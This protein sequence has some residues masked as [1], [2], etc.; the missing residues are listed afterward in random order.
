MIKSKAGE[1]K[2][3]SENLS[4]QIKSRDT[5]ITST[6]AKA[7]EL[8]AVSDKQSEQINVKDIEINMIKSKAAELKAV[9][10]NLSEQIK[11]K[12][13]EITSI[14]AEAAELKAVSDILSEQIII[15]ETEINS[16][17]TSKTAEL[18]V[19]SDKL[20]E[21]IN[22]KEIDLEI[23]LERL[24]EF[25]NFVTNSQQR[26]LHRVKTYKTD[27]RPEILDEI[28]KKVQELEQQYERTRK[29]EDRVAE[30]NKINEKRE[31]KRKAYPDIQD[32]QV[33]P[34][35]VA[36][37]SAKK[38]S[39]SSNSLS[40]KTL[41]K[42]TASGR[43]I[44][45]HVSSINSVLRM[46]VHL[47]IDISIFSGHTSLQ[48]NLFNVLKGMRERKANEIDKL[49]QE[50]ITI[51]N[52][53]SDFE[54][55][56]QYEY[57]PRNLII[58]LFKLCPDVITWK[59]GVRFE[60]TESSF[61][62]K[63]HRVD[64]PEQIFKIFQVDGTRIRDYKLQ[65][66]ETLRSTFFECDTKLVDGYCD[67][68]NREARGTESITSIFKAKILIFSF[69]QNGISIPIA[70][71]ERIFA[72][73]CAYEL[74]CIIKQIGRAGDYEYKRCLCK[75]EEGWIDYS[76]SCTERVTYREVDNCYLLI[77]AQ[78]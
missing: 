28:M 39:V 61:K 74:Y 29:V 5:E 75:D 76:D 63:S 4:E 38:L 30:K 33:L 34:S 13:T 78:V 7:A 50:F 60:H 54:R 72:N 51:L 45:S 73:D 43:I 21:Q 8:K 66:E 17:K 20:S 10:E 52:N 36:H 1:L 55:G 42:G 69:S 26:K 15:N 68:C 9:T 62:G 46:I 18:K 27:D 12:D 41:T 6:K 47:P 23:R 25:D 32:F 48:I 35:N 65:L 49:I 22:A 56:S 31:R 57:D 53:H 37:S 19:I 2:A 3:V 64:Y 16:I 59:R 70:S 67:K 24:T 44:N 11:S 58:F 71:I 40:D 14:K 77:Y